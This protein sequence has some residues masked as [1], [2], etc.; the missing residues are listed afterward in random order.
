MEEMIR[1]AY[2]IHRL[3]ST[4]LD[5]YGVHGRRGEAETTEHSKPSKP[6]K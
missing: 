6:T 4:F 1:P 3:L 2:A 5:V